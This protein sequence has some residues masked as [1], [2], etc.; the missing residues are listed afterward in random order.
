[1]ENLGAFCERTRGAALATLTILVLAA[2]GGSGDNNGGYNNGGPTMGGGMDYAMR[3]VVG[4]VAGGTYGGT[5]TDTHLVNGWGVAFNPQGFVWVANGGTSTSTLYDGNGVPQSLVVSIPDGASGEAEPTGI[6]FSGGTDFVVSQGAVSGP[7]RFIFAGEGGTISAWSP[8]VNATNAITV[9]DGGASGSAFTGLAL[10]AGRLFAAD[11]GA[12]T[13]DVFD[14]SFAPLAV[15]GGFVDATVPAG[16]APF[17]IQAVGSEIV[18]TYAMKDAQSGDEVKGAGLGLVDVFD[19][20][21][22]LLRRLVSPGGVLNAPWGVARAPAD[23]GRFSNALM[24]GNFGDGRL[25]AFDLASGA[26][27]GTLSTTA[28]T[29]LSIDGLWGIAFGNGLNNQPANTLFFAAGPGDETHGAYGRIDV[30]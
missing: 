24:V 28:G 17:G 18:V 10:A 19:T 12:G 14:G 27:L 4:D 7:A 25:H 2:C 13:V 8:A 11:F 6:V 9:F 22:K 3:V 15:S 26:L 23:F 30:N 5:Y 16:Y 20:D 21:G 29:P 1:M